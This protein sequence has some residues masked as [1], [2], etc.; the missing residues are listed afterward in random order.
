MALPEKVDAAT[1]A[2]VSA[3]PAA[4]D[5]LVIEAD[6]LEQNYWR[7][8]WRYRELFYFLAWRDILVRYKQTTI[9]VLWA[10]LR[11]L[12]TMVIFTTVF[13]TVAHLPA[14]GVPYALT[15]FAALLPWQLFSAA[16]SDAGGSL[17]NN[18]NMIT[19]VYFPRLMLPLST[20]AAALVDFFMSL[21]L[22]AILL[23]YYR[24][25]PDWR[26]AT[27]PLFTLLA[28]AAALGPGL[29][30]GAL[31]VRYRDFRY[32]VPFIVQLGIFISPVG[33]TSAVVPARWQL[34]YSLNPMVGVIEGFRWALL[35]GSVDFYWPGFA[36]SLT[37]V[38]FL[39]ITGVIYFRST[40]RSFADVV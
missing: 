18:A 40:E 32:L 12:I 39:L 36:L 31:T 22:F 26:V 17:V 10:V 15:V 11:P 2:R 23:I 38:V 25:A 16:L 28:V 35:G 34:I 14:G 9:G 5:Q 27:L 13:G 24:H 21:A 37:L 7:D 20:I 6:R 4:W 30:F 33:F 1:A 29:W 8:L 3:P 19:K